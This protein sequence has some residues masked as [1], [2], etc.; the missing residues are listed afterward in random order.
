MLNGAN[1]E[2]GSLLHPALSGGLNIA[3]AIPAVVVRQGR[4]QV[5]DLLGRQSG[6]HVGDGRDGPGYRGLGEPLQPDHQ[7][8]DFVP[9]KAVSG[10]PLRLGE[11]IDEAGEFGCAMLFEPLS[12]RRTKPLALRVGQLDVPVRLAQQPL[13]G[14]V[15]GEL[16]EAAP[17]QDNGKERGE[18]Q[19]GGTTMGHG[20]PARLVAGFIR[21][22][23]HSLSTS[24][25]RSRSVGHRPRNPVAR[26]RRARGN[27]RVGRILPRVELV[28]GAGLEPARHEVSGF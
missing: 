22:S 14:M 2:S 27:R 11:E 10:R 23:R 17:H 25:N 6:Q 7:R 19:E 21:G 3:L 16:H 4:P 15:V 24:R 13:V 20:L 1:R 28:P 12:E 5:V 9:R 18:E 8:L 26:I